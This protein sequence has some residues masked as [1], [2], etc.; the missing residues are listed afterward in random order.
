[1]HTTDAESAHPAQYS[2]EVLEAIKPIIEGFCLPVHDPFAGTGVRLGALCDELELP[3]FGIEIEQEFIVDKR[4]FQG[5]STDRWS[6]PRLGSYL[7]VT[8]PVYPNGMADHFEAHDNSRRHT[9][10]QALA[11]VLGHDSPLHEHNMGRYSVR[12]GI[13]AYRRYQTLASD[14]SQWW[15]PNPVV[16]NVSDFIHKD[17]VIPLVAFWESMLRGHGYEIRDYQQIATPRQRFGANAT[18]RVDHEIVFVA[19]AHNV[20]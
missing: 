15:W 12:G 20:G 7:I 17:T 2:R 8:S 14:A 19:E 18:K 13:K 5:D 11:K 6:Y 16:L 9:Y 10:R 4:V 3:F 1:M